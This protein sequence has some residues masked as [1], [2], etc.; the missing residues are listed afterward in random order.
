VDLRDA[1][2][3][4]LAQGAPT[5]AVTLLRRALAEPPPL[6]EHGGVL[7][8]LGIAELIS[9]DPRA[10]ERLGYAIEELDDP[11]AKA[12]AAQARAVSLFWQNRLADAMATIDHVHTE[13]AAHDNQLTL[14]LDALRLSFTMGYLNRPAEW[15]HV[16]TQLRQALRLAKPEAVETRGAA[17][18]VAGLDTFGGCSSS[19]VRA[20]VQQAWGDE[21]LLDALGSEHPLSTYGAVVLWC[22]GELDAFETMATQI[23]HRAATDGSVL[24]TYQALAFRAMARARMGRLADAEA[25][26]ELAWQ[27]GATTLLI[28]GL[29]AVQALLALIAI[30]RGDLASARTR[31]SAIDIESDVLVNRAA[32]AMA[33]ARLARAEGAIADERRTLHEF[34]AWHEA[35]GFATWL[36]G[37]WPAAL[38]LAL[39]ACDEARALA[40]QALTEA[41][42]RGRPGEI[43]IALYAQAMVDTDTPDIERLRSA[44]TELERSELKLEHARALVELGATLRRSGHRKDSRHPLAAGLELAAHCGATALV[45]RARIELQASGARPRRVTLTGQDALTPSELR[46]SLLAAEG[47]SNRD[48]AQALFVTSKTVETHLRHAYQKLNITSR[49]QLPAVLR[50]D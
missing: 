26:A 27:S 8:E 48:I 44:I 3:R 12:A 50:R 14:T 6:G 33:A 4:A 25:D 2:R 23:A 13:V 18:M 47:R 32:Y 19:M 15:R 29:D 1:A 38:A 21:S 9:G 22:A 16:G 37:P 17:I 5:T 45:K 7:L 24:G 30:E 39:G 28:F 35:C 31:L 36:F 10:A 49:T 20:A 34:R 41:R 42:M 11:S 46:I 43:G 40:A